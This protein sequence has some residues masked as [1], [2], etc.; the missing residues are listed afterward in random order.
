MTKKAT[1][2]RI[3]RLLAITKRRA[4]DGTSRVVQV[5]VALNGAITICT[6]V[7]ATNREAALAF[8]RDDG[9]TGLWIVHANLLPPG[10]IAAMKRGDPKTGARQRETDLEP[11]A[12]SDSV[13][14]T[15]STSGGVRQGYACSRGPLQHAVVDEPMRDTLVSIV[16]YYRQ[17][18]NLAC[19][20]RCTVAS[21]WPCASRT[22]SGNQQ[23]WGKVVPA[24]VCAAWDYPEPSKTKPC[25]P[26]D[27]L[28]IHA[29]DW[30]PT[31]TR[32]EAEM[33]VKLLERLDP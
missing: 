23:R 31:P 17:G 20:V 32:E 13:R 27:A 14:C 3:K 28:H 6:V 8:T 29:F 15:I 12:Q 5:D 9:K 11:I 18:T 25:P 30:E 33:F 21:V 4:P 1:D 19:A 16:L 10:V 26:L 22:G 2:A 7:A 24:V